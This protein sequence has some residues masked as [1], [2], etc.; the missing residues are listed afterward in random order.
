M[1]TELEE[2]LVYKTYG[3]SQPEKRETIKKIWMKRYMSNIVIDWG[4][5]DYLDYLDVNEVLMC[6]KEY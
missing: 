4:L 1:L 2:V 6:G 3:S 5:M